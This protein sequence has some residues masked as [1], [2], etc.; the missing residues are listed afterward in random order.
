MMVA[1]VLARLVDCDA[2]EIKDLVMRARDLNPESVW[3]ALDDSDDG[4]ERIPLVPFTELRPTTLATRVV[5][6]P[7]DAD[8][9]DALGHVLGAVEASGRKPDYVVSIH[10]TRLR[11]SAR[12][13]A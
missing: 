6:T 12:D 10:P 5:M 1:I 3:V 4:A 2:S 7:P 8:L 9:Q 11:G 13:D